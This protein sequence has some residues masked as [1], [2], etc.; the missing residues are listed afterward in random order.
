[1]NTSKAAEKA[2]D[3]LLNRTIQL[4]RLLTKCSYARK[5][6]AGSLG[7]WTQTNVDQRNKTAIYMKFTRNIYF[8]YTLAQ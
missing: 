1:M 3:N 4:S 8:Y 2:C 5:P 7:S 6:N